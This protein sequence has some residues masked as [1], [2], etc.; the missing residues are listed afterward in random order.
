MKSIQLQ[1]AQ[2]SN[3]FSRSLSAFN[4]SQKR[5]RKRS[6]CSHECNNMSKV[7]TVSL[8]CKKCHKHFERK[9]SES[10]KSKNHFCSSSCSTFHNNK[11]MQKRP[12]EGLC[13]TCQ[14]PINKKLRYCKICK[15]VM[16]RVIEDN[17]LEDA[18]KGKQGAEKYNT[19]RQRARLITKKWER[20][21]SICG[22]DKHVQ[23]CHLKAINTFPLSTKI[24]EINN[25]ENLKLLCPNCHWEFD[26]M[27]LEDLVPMKGFEPLHESL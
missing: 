16:N 7:T 21:C 6:F 9:K 12:K 22:Y 10:L 20:K 4:Q 25:P 15:D 11:M 24:R 19:I 2:C 3:V 26:H 5:G 18:I 27:L 14:S 8:E 23:T 13:R 1:C 17:T